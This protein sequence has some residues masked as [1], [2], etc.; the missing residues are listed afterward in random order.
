M[1]FAFLYASLR[2]TY[3][4]PQGAF[5]PKASSPA[6]GKGTSNEKAKTGIEAPPALTSAARRIGL[7]TINSLNGGRGRMA[8]PV[9]WNF[10][11]DRFGT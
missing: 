3:Q 9:G 7:S 4:R 6:N 2:R 5:L 1:S 11:W 10:G 8:P